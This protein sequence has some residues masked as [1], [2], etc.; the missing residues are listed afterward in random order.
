MATFIPWSLKPVKEHPQIYGTS[1]LLAK[2][3]KNTFTIFYRY[4]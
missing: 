4:S 3:V 2:G 1:K